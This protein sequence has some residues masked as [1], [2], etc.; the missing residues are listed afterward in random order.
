MT[1]DPIATLRAAVEAH[2]G[3]RC[4]QPAP[5]IER[6]AFGADH[7]PS[8]PCLR[9]AGHGSFC[10]V[11][12]DAPPDWDVLRGVLEACDTLAA[13]VRELEAVAAAA[14]RF[15]RAREEYLANN[16]HNRDAELSFA[17]DSGN[18][19]LDA[20]LLNLPATQPREK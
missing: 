12:G 17:V 4:G 3:P 13:R 9:R 14:R 10:D 6:L 15:S 5:D 8:A 19:E 7:P 1:T 20:A 11:D 2:D 16:D 18:D